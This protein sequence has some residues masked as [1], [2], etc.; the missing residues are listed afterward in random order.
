MATAA[1]IKRPG[2]TVTLPYRPREDRETETLLTMNLQGLDDRCNKPADFYKSRIRSPFKGNRFQLQPPA[3]ELVDTV[4][5]WN[6]L[7]LDDC[8]TLCFIQGYLKVCLEQL[9]QPQL[10]Q[11]RARILEELRSTDRKDWVDANCTE[12]SVL[13]RCRV[14]WARLIQAMLEA[15]D[16]IADH[17]GKWTDTSTEE[18]L[19]LYLWSLD[20]WLDIS[21]PDSEHA[22]MDVCFQIRRVSAAAFQPLNQA[23]VMPSLDYLSFEGLNILPLEGS[24]IA[25][26]PHYHPDIFQKL[27]D[28]NTHVEYSIESKQPWIHWDPLTK[29][30]KGLVPPFSQNSD[31]QRG[32]GQVSRLGS[33]GPYPVIHLVRIDIKAVAVIGY[34]GSNVRL[35]RT[36]RMRLSLRVLPPPSPPDQVAL[37]LARHS[38]QVE[39]HTVHGSHTAVELQSSKNTSSDPSKKERDNDTGSESDT[40]SS[41]SLCYPSLNLG[42]PNLKSIMSY[43]HPHPHPHHDESSASS[44]QRSKFAER[45]EP[46][47]TRSAKYSKEAED[48]DSQH[49]PRGLRKRNDP[50]RWLDTSV[51][52]R[53][54]KG[55]SYAVN[56]PRTVGRQPTMP[57]SGSSESLMLDQV[58][59][60]SGQ[61]RP[62]EDQE[63]TPIS[64]G[65]VAVK[66][67][68]LVKSQQ[69]RQAQRFGSSQV[70]KVAPRRQKVK[71]KDVSTWD[72][73]IPLSDN[74]NLRSYRNQPTL[75]SGQVPV[76]QVSHEDATPLEPLECFNKFSVLQDLSDG[77]SA[78]SV[79]DSDAETQEGATPLEY[80]NSFPILQSLSNDPSA[81]SLGD[82]R[83]CYAVSA[84]SGFED[85]T[86]A[87]DSPRTSSLYLMPGRFRS[88]TLSTGAS[89][90]SASSIPAPP[91]PARSNDDR[92]GGFS[93]STRRDYDRMMKV[94]GSR[95]AVGV[96][97]QPGLSTVEKRQILEALMMSVDDGASRSSSLSMPVDDYIGMGD[98]ESDGDQESEEWDGGCRMRR[99]VVTRG[100]RGR[101]VDSN[102]PH[103]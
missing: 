80:L 67:V 63:N 30:F 77:S 100:S 36:I 60:R 25:I 71:K 76:P 29:A 10:V 94:L 5:T 85:A 50:W 19:M 41:A 4:T 103:C 18:L 2:P 79:V 92:E 17:A 72:L 55:L 22:A 37:T 12:T 33:H 87:S 39:D 14:G 88:D 21:D 32:F 42:S 59:G 93:L 61:S 54:H 81:G 47:V 49:T 78:K 9:L 23:Q 28:P 91:S 51:S 56:T 102:G 96:L 82:S 45:S 83:T 43:P 26:K 31:L 74:P 13:R 53:A 57:T 68:C 95:E 48:L 34:A 11:F 7:T 24:S 16:A 66:L 46:A 99:P 97:Q 38:P 52:P 3:L 90:G 101:G 73:R 58:V 86:S 6:G 98:D 40:A 35:R 65:R 20:C 70:Q 27:G 62:V 15:L 8:E 75:Q 1:S 84:T 44:S 89:T 69:D 64:N